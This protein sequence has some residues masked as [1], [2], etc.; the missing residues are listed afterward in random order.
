M[1]TI[2]GAFLDT[3]NRQEVTIGKSACKI[4]RSV[5]SH[6]YPFSF[7]LFCFFFRFLV[8]FSLPNAYQRK[9][10]IS[11][12]INWAFFSLSVEM[13]SGPYLPILTGGLVN[14]SIILHLFLILSRFP[15]KRESEQTLIEMHEQ[16]LPL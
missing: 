11:L 7:F 15:L 8:I 16:W 6:L 12:Y 14:G 4:Q 5:Q 9:L 1:L 2:R 10:F 13:E 3:G